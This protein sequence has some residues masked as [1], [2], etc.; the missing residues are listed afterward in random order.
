MR[1]QLEVI[2]TDTAGRRVDTS[3]IIEKEGINR[4]LL[5]YETADLV[6]IILDATKFVNWCELESKNNPIEFLEN[7][8]KYDYC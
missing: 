4:A 8:A 1:E 3:D 5:S 6:L 2:L 7:S